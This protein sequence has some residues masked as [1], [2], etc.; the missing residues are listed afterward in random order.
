MVAGIPECLKSV[1]KAMPDFDI[2][3]YGQKE[4]DEIVPENLTPVE[5]SDILRH[6]LIYNE[7]GWWLDADCYVVKTLDGDCAYSLGSQENVNRFDMNQ[8]Q[9]VCNYAFGSEA[10]NPDQKACEEAVLNQTT[11][12][13]QGWGSNRGFSNI[14]GGCSLLA[15]ETYGSRYFACT[16]PS[17]IRPKSPTVLHLFLSSWVDCGCDC[18]KTIGVL[19]K[20]L[21]ASRWV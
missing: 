9:S 17:K 5:K 3:V 6:R 13:E 10:G 12:Y 16:N 15:P 8:W 2:R 1:K 11:H 21:E 19:S 7:G 20:A 14:V 4:L 18:K